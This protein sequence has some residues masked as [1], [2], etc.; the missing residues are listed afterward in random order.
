MGS[1]L[2]WAVSTS[3][4]SGPLGHSTATRSGKQEVLG[5]LQ[6]TVLVKQPPERGASPLTPACMGQTYQ[7]PGARLPEHVLRLQHLTS[8]I[9]VPISSLNWLERRAGSN[10][11]PG[12]GWARRPTSPGLKLL[13]P[14]TEEPGLVMVI[15]LMLINWQLTLHKLLMYRHRAQQL[16][17]C[18]ALHGVRAQ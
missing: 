14:Q 15:V 6:K 7:S 10:C 13:T 12:A 9:P 4:L 17:V 3:I 16:T 5:R 8:A 18:R 1:F 11:R 2:S